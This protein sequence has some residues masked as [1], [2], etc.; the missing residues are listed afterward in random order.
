MRVFISHTVSDDKFAGQL[1]DVLTREGF[2]VW[3]P[4]RN[5]L[6]GDNWLVE[7]GRALERADAVVFLLSDS[8]LESPFAKREI[9][10]V[11]GHPK[12]EDHV[13]TVRLG[14]ATPSKIPW[15][16]RKLSVIDATPADPD[17]TAR[18]VA[19]RLRPTSRRKTSARKRSSK[20]GTKTPKAPAARGA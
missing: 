6:P 16:L 5:L 11:I 2:E 1:R 18:E 4:D 14:K 12:F 8:A 7:T 20:L 19:L 9:Q 13:V 10:Y 15:I 17:K 3:D